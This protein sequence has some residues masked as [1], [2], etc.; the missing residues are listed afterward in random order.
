MPDWFQHPGMVGYVCYADRFAGDLRGLASRLDYLSELGVTYLHLMPLLRSRP[1]ENDGGYAVQAYD[2]VDPRARHHGRPGG[3]GRRA[4]RAGDEPVHRPGHEPHRSRARLGAE[5]R[6]RRPRPTATTTCFFPDRSEPDAYERTLREVFPDFA[7]GNFTFA[8]RD[9][10]VGLDDVQ[11]V[12]V[13]PQ[14]RQPG[15]LLRHVHD[16]GAAGQPRRRGPAARRGAVHL[17]AAGHRLR[18]PAR[19][20]TTCWSP[21]GPCWPS[22]RRPWC[23]RPRPS[24]RRRRSCATW[25]PAT[26]SGTECELAYHN[27]LMVML[28]CSLATGE[29]RLMG[30][31]LARMG[32]IPTTPSWVTY[33]RCHDDI[34]WAVTDEDAGSMGWGGLGH[35]HFLN[36]FYSRRV[37]R[38]VRPRGAVPAER[39]H[40]RRPHLG[41]RGV[42]V[43]RRGRR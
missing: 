18:E 30:N 31:A 42:P 15:R 33:V 8:A 5:G 22:S 14:L 27:Q 36:D 4:A 16:H 3:V 10:G 6:C 35:R 24:S 32:E 19:G 23:S 29:A 17:E 12:P 20:R 7:P 38:L 34:G 39:G 26:P 40:G 1:G 43:R 13:G 25:A 37:R 9:G 21:S 41:H 28:W 11:R 2:E